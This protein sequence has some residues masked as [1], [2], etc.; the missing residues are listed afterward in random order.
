[1]KLATGELWGVVP[2]SSGHWVPQ[3][4]PEWLLFVIACLLAVSMAV[5]WFYMATPI[6][7]D[8]R[9]R[10]G[11]FGLLLSLQFLLVTLVSAALAGLAWSRQDLLSASVFTGVAVLTAVMALWPTI[12]L[13]RRAREY[14]RAD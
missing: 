6:G 4:G 7:Y 10:L 12:A 3:S 9:G 8:R 5:T 11:L 14:E 13:L 2:A 1:M